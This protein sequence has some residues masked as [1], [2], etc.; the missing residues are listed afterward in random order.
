MAEQPQSSDGLV[1]PAAFPV[2]SGQMNVETVAGGGAN[3]RAMGKTVDTHMDN[4][5]GHWNGL[6]AV[7]AGP[8]AEQA[9]GLMAPAATSSE[10]LKNV[11]DKAATAIETYA[12]TLRPIKTRLSDLEREATAFEQEAR[13]GYDGKSWKEHQPAVDRNAELLGRY[14]QIIE[15]LTTASSTCANTINGLCTQSS[16]VKVEAFSA[17]AI[18]ASGEM[19]PWGAPVEKDRNCGESVVHGAGNFLKSTWDGAKGLVGFGEDGWSWSNLGKTWLGVADFVGSTVL[20]AN[21]LVGEGIKLI[22]GD[23]V[24]AWVDRR[25][26]V[27]L[28][29]WTGFVGYDYM[30]AKQGG[31]GW[32]KWKEDGVAALTESVLNIGTCFIPAAG[33]AG[34]AA[35]VGVTGSKLANVTTKV[36]RVGMNVADFAIPGGGWAVKAGVKVF[37]IG[38][39]VVK[40]TDGVPLKPV[41]NP[42]GIVANTPVSNALDLAGGKPSVLAA[43]D[44]PSLG[45]GTPR[46]SQ[47]GAGVPVNHVPDLGDLGDSAKVS[48]PGQGSGGADAV[49]AG[50]VPR[51]PVDRVEVP[52]SVAAE[53]AGGSAAGGRGAHGG[54][55][56]VPEVS[57]GKAAGVDD[58]RAPEV[59]AAKVP[60]PE[61][62]PAAG[63][64]SDADGVGTPEAERVP[65]VEGSKAADQPVDARP[66][67]GG[68]RTPEA[69]RVPEVD[70]GRVPEPEAAP[71]AGRGS[72]A[73]GV[74]T[75]EPDAAR[76]ADP[77]VTVADEVQTSE[78]QESAADVDAAGVDVDVRATD[79]DAGDGVSDVPRVADDA[80]KAGDVFDES[81]HGDPSRPPETDRHGR[82]VWF[83]EDG[84]RHIDGDEGGTHRDA[85]HNLRRG[86]RWIE[87][88]NPAVPSETVKA[89]YSQ[90]DLPGGMEKHLDSTTWDENGRTYQGDV[91]HR[92]GLQDE[93]RE[94]IEAVA[95]IADEIGLSRQQLAEIKSGDVAGNVRRLMEDG[96]CTR[97][98]A[99]ELRRAIMDERKS[100]SALSE[101]SELLGERAADGVI[102]AREEISLFGNDSRPGAGH[103]DK[104]GVSLDPPSITVYEAKGGRAGLGDAL[105]E[106]IRHQQGTGAYLEKL[107]V[108]DRRFRK[109][110]M[111][112]L[113]SKG[114]KGVAFIDAL[115]RG[116][117]ILN[118]DLVRARP[119]G[120]IALS[121]FD[122]KSPPDLGRILLGEG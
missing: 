114:S 24:D 97:R 57:A 8:G 85:G 120:T 49:A 34:A 10:T 94:K 111:E 39:D 115:K 50:E 116:E 74:G 62:A 65:E 36:A 122:M 79:V 53:S 20:L 3:L 44:V 6:P 86:N 98:E 95:Y 35:K 18:M 67:G 113:E 17:E 102:S 48:K 21:P 16:P 77:E 109:D 87:D 5:V 63:R 112:L 88:T 32:H 93:H 64:G 90:I 30:T 75:P 59:E 11:L 33:Q 13:A 12:E 69:E 26:D 27:A 70:A 43:A 28:T 105:V 76:A 7:Y 51:R 38:S 1:C 46:V 68:A 72:D 52:E 56:A 81:I 82:P 121:R 117:V 31:D 73:D 84:R 45:S 118:Y 47:G 42:A 99:R 41:P 19:M 60:E 14:A 9:Y 101:A 58:V 29:A 61:A 4:I 55:D 119:S 110:L 96:V 71:A 23:E 106:G 92:S 100:L 22:G 108:Q 78:V 104:V 83:D 91:E 54:A 80:A 25:H 2:K 66:E 89:K 40:V 107:L 15:E 103:L 37:D